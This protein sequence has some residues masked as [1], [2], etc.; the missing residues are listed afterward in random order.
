[1]KRPL[2]I[3]MSTDEEWLLRRADLE[4]DDMSFSAGGLYSG[5]LS[6]NTRVGDLVCFIEAV[7][8]APYAPYYN[9]YRNHHFKIVSFHEGDH[10]EL[11]CVT[12]DVKVK[13]NVE[14]PLLRSLQ[15]N[16]RCPIS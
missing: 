1:M 2:E 3:K 5:G 7:Y 6:K 15:W 4:T 8:K 16:K 12:G 13:G 10:V 14:R 11:E 9:D